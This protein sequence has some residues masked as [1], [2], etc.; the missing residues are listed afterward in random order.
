MQRNC[1][2]RVAPFLTFLLSLTQLGGTSDKHQTHSE[3]RG[4]QARYQT[5]TP[6]RLNDTDK[7][8][9][10]A[11]CGPTYHTPGTSRLGTRPA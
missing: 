9:K 2:T 5:I 1:F 8:V 7:L 4:R 6:Y 11:V 10:R 3:F